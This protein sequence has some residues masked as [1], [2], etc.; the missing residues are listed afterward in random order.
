MSVA[1]AVKGIHHVT[2]IS[3]VA[4]ENVDFYAGVLGLR[5]VKKT[6]NFDDPGTYHLYYGDDEGRPGSIL[7]FFPWAYA[8]QGRAGAGMVGA[9]SFMISN[10]SLDDW[11]ERL[12]ESGVQS[13]LQRSRFGEPVLLF[14]DPH[15][16]DLELVPARGGPG[17]TGSP[18]ATDGVHSILGFYGVTLFVTEPDVTASIITDIF[19]YE[20]VAHEEGRTRFRSPSGDPGSVIDLVR[21]ADRGR[22][23]KGTTHHVA[24]RAR[25][26]EQ[27]LSLGEAL[28][29][30]GLHV[31]EVKDRNYF[32]SIYFREPNGVLFEIATDAPGFAVDEPME[33]L[34]EE[35]K[36]PQWLEPRRS[37]IERHLEGLRVPSPVKSP[38]SSS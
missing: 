8:T 7:T 37:E 20:F 13:P 1:E 30:A 9:T 21:R 19:G 34:G 36:L 12:E 14:R 24:F 10:G 33:H 22:Q 31:T 28:G 26:E 6:V 32:K 5:F 38:A 23:G 15:G 11:S 17:A 16:L 18:R 4:Q 27:Q 3:G 29:S 35:L 2:A 25:D